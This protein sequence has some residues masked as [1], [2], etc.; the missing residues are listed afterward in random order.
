MRLRYRNTRTSRRVGVGVGRKQKWNSSLINKK[1][2]FQDYCKSYFMH[3]GYY[4]NF[5]RIQCNFIL[6]KYTHL[7]FHFSFIFIIFFF[8][9][10]D[11][12]ECFMFRFYRRPLMH[13][14][15]SPS[16]ISIEYAI[17]LIKKMK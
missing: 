6:Y 5:F 7:F 14:C 3:F 9:F 16:S 1:G 11:V 10:R 8:V 12:P 15:M 17:T 4:M 2:A 13:T